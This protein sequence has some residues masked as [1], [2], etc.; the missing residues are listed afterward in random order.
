MVG[1]FVSINLGVED[2]SNLLLFYLLSLLSSHGLE[3]IPGH[4]P[5]LKPFGEIIN[6]LPFFYIK[7]KSY[8]KQ[9]RTEIV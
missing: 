9:K 2:S 1:S 7:I 3:N 6:G 5:F 8:E 4:I